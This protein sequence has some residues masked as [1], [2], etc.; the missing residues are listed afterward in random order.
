V[1]LEL[2]V[3]VV[4]EVMEVIKASEVVEA[5]A[6]AEAASCKGVGRGTGGGHPMNWMQYKQQWGAANICSL[7][8]AS[9]GS[10]RGTATE[11]CAPC[12]QLQTPET[13]QE[14]L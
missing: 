4:A 14:L 9:G 2:M 3:V 1:L 12:P 13:A 11:A 7:H 10:W 8:A 6:R 5:S